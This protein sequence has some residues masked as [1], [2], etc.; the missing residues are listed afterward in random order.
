MEKAL[1]EYF[2]PEYQFFLD[3]IQYHRMEDVPNNLQISLSCTDNVTV[4]LKP[5]NKATI[6]L[7]REIRF[8]PKGIFSLEIKFGAVLTF[9]AEASEDVD[10]KKI[11]LADEFAKNG[12]FVMNN[13]MSRSSLLAA[14]ITAS[15]GR[16]PLIL[17][18]SIIK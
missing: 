12:D 16:Q 8:D 13:L 3:E 7:A 4:E 1:H 5:E 17:P 6:I 11:N 18:G 10:W 14:E 15:Y 2:L 9:N